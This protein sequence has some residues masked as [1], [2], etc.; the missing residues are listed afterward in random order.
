MHCKAHTYFS[1]LLYTLQGLQRMYSQV[2]LS[3][4]RTIQGQLSIDNQ[5]GKIFSKRSWKVPTLGRSEA[6]TEPQKTEGCGPAVRL[7]LRENCRQ[8]VL[9]GE[10]VF[11]DFN[12]LTENHT[13]PQHQMISQLEVAIVYSFT[14]LSYFCTGCE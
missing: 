4:L 8:S 10:T 11:Q 6:D 13:E 7:L 2:L 12:E 9:A 5:G 1:L 14:F 3:A